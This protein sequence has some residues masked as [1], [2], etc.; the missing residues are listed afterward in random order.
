MSTRSLTI[1]LQAYD[2]SERARGTGESK[3]VHGRHRLGTQLKELDTTFQQLAKHGLGGAALGLLGIENGVKRRR[4]RR[5]WHEALAAFS[6]DLDPQVDDLLAQGVAVDAE[7][8]RRA[9]LIA[10]SFLER[11]LNQ[12]PLD[13]FDH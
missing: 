3:K 7:N 13:S 2:S 5:L 1:R 9:N 6:F 10:T 4:Q 12:R 11:Q 8:L